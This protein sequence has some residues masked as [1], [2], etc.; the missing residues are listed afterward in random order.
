VPEC[1]PGA[2]EQGKAA[3]PRAAQGPLQSVACAVADIEFAACGGLADRD[4]DADARTPIAGMGQGSQPLGGGAVERGKACRRA[5]VMSCTELGS[6][7]ETHSG[8]PSGAST[9]WMLPPCVCALPE[10]HKSIASPLTLRA[11]SL[12]RLRMVTAR[13]GR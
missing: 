6:T 2:G 9:A 5:A 1:P 4:V 12:Q 13:P 7:P 10:Y 11:G 8:N 3:F